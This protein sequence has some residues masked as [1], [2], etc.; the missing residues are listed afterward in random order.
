MRIGIRAIGTQSNG[1]SRCVLGR[2]Q[3]RE[4][5][6]SNQDR[7]EAAGRNRS[8]RRGSQRFL[9]TGDRGSGARLRPARYG[10]YGDCSP[11]R[12]ASLIKDSRRC[13]LRTGWRRLAA[14]GTAW[15]ILMALGWCRCWPDG[16]SLPASSS[17]V[18]LAAIQISKRAGAQPIALL[19]TWSKWTTWRVHGA[20]A[21]RSHLQEGRIFVREIKGQPT[22]KV[23]ELVGLDPVGGPMFAKSEATASGGLLILWRLASAIRSSSTSV[24]HLRP[25]LRQSAASPLPSYTTDRY[26]TRHVE[27]F[28]DE[29]PGWLHFPR[30]CPHF[31]LRRNCRGSAPASWSA[32]QPD[33]KDC[34]HGSELPNGD[35]YNAI[36]PRLS[37]V[38]KCSWMARREVSRSKLKLAGGCLGGISFGW[39]GATASTCKARETLMN[40][41]ASSKKEFSKRQV[42]S[43]P[44]TDG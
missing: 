1:K 9:G 33:R 3:F 25:H 31:P 27:R 5:A 11:A 21:I 39:A 13:E 15:G 29:G 8:N 2:C 14:Y 44:L 24:P 40:G 4:A 42:K 32:R 26:P 28:V 19:R 41:R 38:L 34:G 30:C 18:G 17:S 10:L 6:S 43:R 16:S 23:Q 22:A 35:Q 20:A 7:P 36:Q 37:R 12:P